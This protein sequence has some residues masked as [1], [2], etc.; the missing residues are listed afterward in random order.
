MAST[1]AQRARQMPV[2]FVSSTSEDLAHYRK[3]AEQGV[4]LAR[5]FP[6]VHELWVAKDKPPLDECLAR[7]RKADVLV[8]IVA[9]RHGWVPVDQAPP[10]RHSI[11]RLE[12][13]ESARSGKEVL[14]FL[15]DESVPWP[16]ENKEEYRLVEAARAGSVLAVA[17]EV[18]DNINRL[19]AFKA[20]LRGRGIRDT[21]NSPEDL[22]GKVALALQDW[23]QRHPEFDTGETASAVT[24]QRD[25][26]PYLESL[27]DETAYIDIRG[28]RTSE[29]MA[30][31]FAINDLYVPLVNELA[32]NELAER[33]EMHMPEAERNVPLDE[34]LKH[35]RL[36]IV[37]DPGAG[38]STFL[39]RI[40]C[41]ICEAQLSRVATTAPLN[42]SLDADT[43]PILMRVSDLTALISR[44]AAPGGHADPTDS[45]MWI[46]RLLEQQCAALWGLDSDFFLK[47]LKEGP[48]LLAVDGLD[49]APETRTRERVARIVSN[50]AR[51][52]PNCRIVVTTRPKAYSEDAL[53]TGFAEARIGSL[54][55]NTVRMFLRRWSEALFAQNP[56]KAAQHAA[57]LVYA[58]E[59]RADIRR[60]AQNPVMLTALAVL[61]WN[62]KRL[63][64]Q[65]AELY[66]SVLTWLAQ[67]RKLKPNRPGAER[68]IALLQELAL[69]LQNH[70]AGRQVQ[71]P[72]AWAAEILSAELSRNQYKR[73]ANRTGLSVSR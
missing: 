66:E 9:Y 49:E 21:F 43:F 42:S 31:R 13:E 11:T 58:V 2:A 34:A 37:G 38:K 57:E 45:P 59:S 18:Q 64:Q 17:A 35:T 29:G 46:V 12:C 40:V 30:H 53:L 54:D 50:A 33:R 39:K 36:V 20:W 16:E 32:Q 15:V 62:E 4:Q 14:A 67:S 19:A 3:A 5:C 56:G 71:A 48:C 25:V 68:C 52:W 22:R 72:R 41:S 65:R 63:P 8:V 44:P 23:K 26:T 1:T 51:V 7:V 69:A 70:P 73:R 6:E 28:L 61:H 10:E 47:R 55:K 27:R 24:L 60:I